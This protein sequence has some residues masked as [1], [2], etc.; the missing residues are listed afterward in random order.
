MQTFGIVD[1]G[2]VRDMTAEEVEAATYGPITDT[3]R[4]DAIGKDGFAVFCNETLVAGAW[5][6]EW[7][8]VYS[9]NR[10]TE[11]GET[12]REALDKGIIAYR[13]LKKGL[14]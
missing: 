13:S 14:Q 5:V 3:D 6:F 1:N 12:L 4:I 8:C 2:V 7:H 11:L 9:A 10:P